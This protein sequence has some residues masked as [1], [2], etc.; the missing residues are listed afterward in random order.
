MRFA[1]LALLSLGCA[2]ATLS[3]SASTAPIE[4]R[5]ASYEKLKSKDQGLRQLTLS[6]GSEV[7]HI[8]D[9]LAVIPEDSKAAKQAKK[10]Q[11]FF[12]PGIVATSATLAL[13]ATA[14]SLF[15]SGGVKLKEGS[16]TDNEALI[17]QGLK[18][19]LIGVGFGVA[20]F[21]AGIATKHFA[22]GWRTSREAAFKGYNSALK[23]QLNLCEQ[24]GQLMECQQF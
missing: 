21:P 2:H 8:E 6:D 22:G 4:E 17:D 24:D 16:D 20:L 1:L 18:T 23:K 9:M 12:I 13:S 7:Y 10:S 19:M 14:L 3:A 15:A 5:Q 11:K